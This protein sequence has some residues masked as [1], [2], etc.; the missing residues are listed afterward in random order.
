MKVLEPSMTENILS[1]GAEVEKFHSRLLRMSLAI[2]ESRE[3]WEHN[4]LRLS[5][6]D[7]EIVAFE[8]RWFG[9]KSLARVRTILK[10]FGDRFDTY[11]IALGV[12]Q[13]WCPSELATRQN[14]CH[15]HLQ[16]SDPIYRQFSGIF[17]EQR[18]ANGQHSI[19][20]DVVVRWLKER[21]DKD[22]S[23]AT[24]I[25]MAT[26]L[27]TCASNAGLCSDKSGTRQLIYPQVTDEALTYWLYFLRHLSF[28]GSLWT[29]PYFAS[30]GLSGRLLEQRL[31]RLQDLGSALKER[32]N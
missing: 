7:K 32:K 12:L 17:L 9:N 16:L 27:I 31:N 3:Y 18:R 19:D 4:D 10:N 8:K 6:K 25:R 26:A 13:Q 22:W 2:E 1:C 30:V 23:S 14:I 28:A 20:R 21:L 24:T 29:N 11:P 5:K 15:W